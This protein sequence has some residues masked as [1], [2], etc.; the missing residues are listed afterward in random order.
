MEITST[1]KQPFERCSLDIVGPLTESTS[2]NKYILTFQDDLSKYL[3]AIPIP[4]QDAETVARAFVLNIVLKFGAPA[5]LLTDQGSNFLSDLFKNMCR[6]L[7]IKKVQ[8]T[9]FRPESNGGLERSHRVLAEYLRHYVSEAQTDW[10]DWVPYA[11][12][13]YNS[14]V[15]STTKFTP[16]ELVYGFKSEVPSAL[17]ET[18]TVQYNYDDYVMELKGRLQ[19]SHE[20]AR[21]RLLSGKE[22]SK[23]YYDKGSEIP[24]IQVGQKI[25]IFDKTVRRGRSKKLSPQYI[26]PYDVLA[27]EGVNVLIK[28]GRSTQK[29]HVNRVKPYY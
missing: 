11:V 15:H 16:F 22:R 2:G 3:A 5:Q 17:R 29:I 9:P 12:Y 24:T 14:T 1:A 27:V 13:M 20:I 23:E 7:R 25:L 10:D 19:S 26:G 18:P 8:T 4:Q 28:R 6:L 21:Q